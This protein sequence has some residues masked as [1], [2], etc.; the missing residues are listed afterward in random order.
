MPA[1]FLNASPVELIIQGYDQRINITLFDENGDQVDATQLSLRVLDDG[2]RLLFTDDFFVPPSPPTRIKKPAGTIGEYYINWGDPAFPNQTETTSVADRRFIWRAVG[3]VDTEPSVV[4]QVVKIA[5]PRSMAMLPP[6]RLQIDKAVKII[7]ER[8]NCFLGYTD[9]MLLMFL[10]GG[11]NILNT[12]QPNTFFHL[13]DFPSTHLQL[14]IDVATL[15]ALNSQLMFAI[16]TDINYSDQGYSFQIGHVQPLQSLMSNLQS[17]ID[18][19]VP[20]FKLNFA[21]LGSMHIE[22]GTSFRLLQLLQSSMPGALFR[23]YL[24]A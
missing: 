8:T 5:D 4:L 22:A 14:L 15:V 24:T 9:A 13:E 20:L 6:F 17:R 19:L 16:D 3:G 7:D 10:E 2:N 21:T 1:P 12:Y 11:L 23:G 18:R